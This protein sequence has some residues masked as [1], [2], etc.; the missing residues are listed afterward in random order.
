ML[1]TTTEETELAD[2]YE[3][4]GQITLDTGNLIIMKSQLEQRA[5]IELQ[6]L[7]MEGSTIEVTGVEAGA[8]KHELL[9]N[10]VLSGESAL[11]ALKQLTKKPPEMVAGATVIMKDTPEDSGFLACFRCEESLSEMPEE[12]EQ[13]ETAEE[14]QQQ[15]D[16][17]EGET[18]DPQEEAPAPAPARR[19]I[20]WDTISDDPTTQYQSSEY[21]SDE[22]DDE[23]KDLYFHERKQVPGLEPLPGFSG[24]SESGSAFACRAASR[25]DP[26]DSSIGSVE[27]LRSSQQDTSMIEGSDAEAPTFGRRERTRRQ[28]DTDASEVT[29]PDSILEHR[30]SPPAP[31]L[32]PLTESTSEPH[33][34]AGKTENRKI[35]IDGQWVEV[36]VDLERDSASTHNDVPPI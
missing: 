28:D 34:A 6:A 31:G 25:S 20:D 33:N 24:S 18:P 9:L 5:Q 21:S 32:E 3:I 12:E 11:R 13:L 4:Q 22:T 15:E 19:Q 26:A 7:L 23:Y 29:D 14:E 30:R 35:Y 36:E 16:Q 8:S 2:A 1:T 17:A 27:L 10:F